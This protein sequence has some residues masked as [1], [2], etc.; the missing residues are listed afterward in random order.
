MPMGT[1]TNREVTKYDI[2]SACQP[3][4]DK[5]SGAGDSMKKNLT[6]QEIQIKG[7][8]QESQ[9]AVACGNEPIPFRA[10][11]YLYQ[12]HTSTAETTVAMKIRNIITSWL[13]L[14]RI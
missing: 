2:P 1:N 4:E 13:K 3:K 11:R 12:N 6:H 10:G 8:M 14:K 5:F 7:T 9:V